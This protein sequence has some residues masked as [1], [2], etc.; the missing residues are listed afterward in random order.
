MSVRTHFK[1]G[2]ALALGA[3]LLVAACSE[4]PVRTGPSSITAA[5]STNIVNRQAE[6]NE[7]ELCKDFSAPPPAGTTVTFVVRINR[8]NTGFG[9]PFNIQLA[10]GACTIVAT[11]IGIGRDVVEV[12]EQVPAGF[13]TPTWVRT[14]IS[15]DGADTTSGTGATVS[16]PIASDD[17]GTLV[18]FTNTADPTVE[19]GTGRMTGG[20]QV[21]VAGVR[22]SKGLTIHCDKL[23]SNNLEVNWG[24]GEKFH[25]DEHITTIACTDDPAIIQAPPAAP[26]DTLIGVG[27]GEY[28]GNPG[29]TVEF[30]FIDYGEPG[31]LDRVALKI[32]PTGSPNSPVLSFPVTIVSNGNIQ[33]HFDQPHK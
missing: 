4:S 26:L 2:L 33:A 27:T 21:I 14:V 1:A 6:G 24:Q 25:M 29:Y 7:F 19:P 15:P 13:Q 32:Y 11:D 30:T 17:I 16:G 22:I 5:G 18:I 31:T 8:D 3:A 9:A 23:L 20:G 10:P 28:N 12:T